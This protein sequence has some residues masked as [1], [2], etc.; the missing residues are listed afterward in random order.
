[1]KHVSHEW[2]MSHIHTRTDTYS[3]LETNETC[4]TWICHVTHTHT[5]KHILDSRDQWNM[6]H[7]NVSSSVTH[8]SSSG[9]VVHD[10][11]YMCTYFEFCVC[12]PI[13]DTNA[14]GCM[15]HIHHTYNMCRESLTH[16]TSQLC[17]ETHM[18]LDS[19]H[20]GIVHDTC[21][22]INIKFQ[23]R[24]KIER[25]MWANIYWRTRCR[26]CSCSCSIRSCSCSVHNTG[27]Y[28]VASVSRID[29][30]IGLF[31]KRVL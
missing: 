13:H 15:I 26:S 25:S 10:T 12:I 3:T 27:G 6:S 5:H 23:N 28:G 14:F 18:H 20:I 7:M 8:H 4:L 21:I 16:A 17:D 30:I 19:L 24:Y 22:K 29:K 31:C 11:C 9:Y 2:V 1:M